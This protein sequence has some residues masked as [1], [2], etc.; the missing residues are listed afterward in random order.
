MD[1]SAIHMLQ[2]IMQLEA[3]KENCKQRWCGKLSHA[4]E[5]MQ[6]CRWSA[7]FQFL[8]GQQQH[9]QPGQYAAQQFGLHCHQQH[10]GLMAASRHASPSSTVPHAVQQSAIG[11]QGGPFHS[12]HLQAHDMQPGHNARCWRVSSVTCLTLQKIGKGLQDQHPA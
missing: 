11:H 7:I 12:S 6:A 4:A 2:N 8:S 3:M 9:I 5:S 10:A 1:T